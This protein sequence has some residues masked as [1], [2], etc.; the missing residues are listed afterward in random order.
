[1]QTDHAHDQA[2]DELVQALL[3][4]DNIE[5]KRLLQK[6]TGFS[7]LRHR[8]EILIVPALERVGLK[9]ERGEAALSQVYLS[10]RI[11]EEQM[12][13]LFPQNSS[14]R[15]MDHPRLAI[16]VLEDFHLLGK[17]MVYS[18]LRAAG[19]VVK[20]AVGGAPFRL[21]ADLWQEVGADAMGYNASDVIAIV[22]QLKESTR[23]PQ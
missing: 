18:T 10:G 12:D 9:W 15:L 8:I 2:I 3:S 6:D 4:L 13:T 19:L 14:D 22:R 17:R 23:C 7:E 11:C 16:A 1:M 5:V 20:V 21:D